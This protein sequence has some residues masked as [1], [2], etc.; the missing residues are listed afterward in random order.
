MWTGLFR[1][2]C[3]RADSGTKKTGHGYG[4]PPI[5]TKNQTGPD[6]GTLTTPE[7]TREHSAH[8]SYTE[9][10]PNIFFLI[11]LIVLQLAAIAG[12]ITLNS[13]FC[14]PWAWAVRHGNK[15][16]AY[17]PYLPIALCMQYVSTLHNRK[18]RVHQGLPLR[19]LILSR[20]FEG[21]VNCE[22]DVTDNASQLQRGL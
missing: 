4:C 7:R 18:I 2:S 20:G 5:G 17:G 14:I 22:A 6:L 19:G 12:L 9:K 8:R 10:W 21:F 11:G 13:T 1:S 15:W 16:S 3:S